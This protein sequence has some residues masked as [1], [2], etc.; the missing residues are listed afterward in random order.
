MTLERQRVGDNTS[1]ITERQLL[2]AVKNGDR[3]AMRSLY[4]RYAGYAMATATRY[5]ADHDDVCDVVQD[6]FIK[7]FTTIGRFGYRGEGSLK[8]WINRIVANQAIDLLKSRQR[9]TFVS[10]VPDNSFD[11]SPDVERVPPDVL[12]RLIAQLPTGYRLVL[13]LFVFEQL[14]H[15]EIGRQ[16]GIVENTSASQYNRA[17]N[18]LAM[19]IKNYLKQQER[20]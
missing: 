20:R 11:D 7:I 15:K 2:E 14:S 3:R 13:N 5:V 8:A 9:V 12:T 10:D 1:E 17:K 19:M 16:L 6:S 18:K 4:D